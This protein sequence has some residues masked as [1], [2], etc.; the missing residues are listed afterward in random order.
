MIAA[1]GLSAGKP[2]ELVT[3]SQTSWSDAPTG[4]W[5]GDAYYIALPTEIMSSG[6]PIVVRLL[7]VAADGT[8]SRVADI[9]QGRVLGRARLRAPAPTTCA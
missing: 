1:D 6:Y 7:R 9:L 3:D 2:Q 8:M 5:I 4:A